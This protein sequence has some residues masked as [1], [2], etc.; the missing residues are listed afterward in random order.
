M[1]D[2]QDE[3]THCQLDVV[4]QKDMGG[5]DMGG[6]DMLESNVLLALLDHCGAEEELRHTRERIAQYWQIGTSVRNW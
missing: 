3:D 2:V 5:E 6:I 1:V 4:E